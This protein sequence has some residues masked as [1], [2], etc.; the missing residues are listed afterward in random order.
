MHTHVCSRGLSSGAM[1]CPTSAMSS[2]V[3]LTLP[4]YTWERVLCSA[5]KT[6]ARYLALALE[7][8]HTARYP[9][10][11]V[12][13]NTG[14]TPTFSGLYRDNYTQ[15]GTLCQS[16]TKRRC[17]SD[18]PWTVLGQPHTARYPCVRV[19]PN[20]GVT[21][22]FLGL[23]QDNCTQ[24]D[25]RGTPCVTVSPNAG[26]TLTFPG[27]YQDSHTRLGTPMSEYPRTPM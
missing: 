3:T 14:V 20:A 25:T 1:F 17:N 10:A 26:V 23:Y 4:G 22:T 12:S 6:L 7:Q 9:Y 8:P 18:I 27:L 2:L 13:P 21:L 5:H 11:I 16:I 24:L 19:S 15:L